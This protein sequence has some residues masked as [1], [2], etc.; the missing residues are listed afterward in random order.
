MAEV[1]D[2][3]NREAL[4]KKGVYGA[5]LVLSPSG[6]EVVHDFAGKRL[7]RGLTWSEVADFAIRGR[8]GLS[9]CG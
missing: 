3:L 8:L 9:G 1:A 4:L 6:I 5:K 7:K 2:L